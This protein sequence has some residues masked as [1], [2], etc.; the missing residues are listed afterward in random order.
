MATMLCEH[1]RRSAI[2]QSCKQRLKERRVLMS[3]HDLNAML[4]E[5]RRESKR[6][7]P[8]NPRLS[9]ENFHGHAA[10]GELFAQYADLVIQTSED[11]SVAVRKFSRETCCQN[12]RTSDIQAVQ[13]LANNRSPVARWR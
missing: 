4:T 13:H 10:R 6:A 3:V 7:F 8:V 1:D 2:S 9:M 11:E 5:E 12:F